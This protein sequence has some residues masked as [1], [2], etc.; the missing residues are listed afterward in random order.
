[1]QC[2]ST[3]LAWLVDAKLPWYVGEVGDNVLLVSFGCRNHNAFFVEV[4]LE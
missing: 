2:K 1:M 4:R 3:T